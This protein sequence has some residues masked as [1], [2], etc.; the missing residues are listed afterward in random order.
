MQKLYTATVTATGDGRRGDITSSD[1]VLA[2]SLSSPE[3]MGGAGEGGTNPEQLFAGGYAA[4]F[5]SAI[6][7]AARR[8]KATV[9][10]STVTC[11]VTL[12]RMQD[13]R[14]TISAT[15]SVSMPGVGTAL[16][17]ELIAEADR[18]CPYSNA[19]RGDAE[20]TLRAAS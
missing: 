1:G 6:R 13:G 9:E 19:C 3:E 14:Y 12:N 18:L 5:H 8:R 16:A 20:V 17:A 2:L 11:A 4:C 7:A 10:G 15:L